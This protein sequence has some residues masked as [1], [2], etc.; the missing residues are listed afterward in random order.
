MTARRHV[1]ITIDTLV[2]RGV[3]AGA[4]REVA[5][6]LTH[7]LQR[8]MSADGIAERLG[9]SRSVRVLPSPPLQNAQTSTGL[10]ASAAARIVAGLAR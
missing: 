8:M 3:P 1:T 9:E 7:E 2:L 5:E 6:A 4:Q 10:G